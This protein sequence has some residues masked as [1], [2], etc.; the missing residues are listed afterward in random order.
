MSIIE[1]KGLAR[2]FKS[3]KR[4]VNAVRGVDLTVEE[5]EIVG[6]LGPNGAGK[7]TTLRMLTTLL[8]PT[9]GTATVAGQDLLRDP[10]GVRR[11]IGFVPQAIGQTMGG[12]DNQ[13]TVA[14]EILDQAALYR[15]G[16]TE[17]R[18]RAELLTSQ[19]DLTGLD[20][21]L[22]KTLS[23]G[24][25]RRLEIALG[26][27]HE[28][29]LVFLD[30]PTTGLDPQ[31]RSNMWDHIRGVRADLGTTVFLTTHYLDEADALCDRVFI[32]DNGEIVAEGTPDELKRRV[33]GDIV[34]LAVSGS[35][36]EARE[37]LK[38][39][40]IVEDVTVADDG[41]LRL[42]VSHGAEALPSLLR[43]L[44]DAGITMTSINLSRPTLDDVFLTTTGRS[45]R[46]DSPSAAAG[47]S[48]AAGTDAVG[49]GATEPGQP[50]PAGKE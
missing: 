27:V 21:R 17:A 35:G 19:L 46:D 31:S 44:D 38:R 5:G 2:T 11:R 39:Q 22:V 16:K 40:P 42:S 7:T 24:Q 32:I 18:R 28:P 10:L 48:S 12:T 23:G 3:R 13:S 15:I 6:F 25:R 47:T 49:P 1:A 36:D 8:T 37:L 9:A 20:Q 34:T 50:E 30:E 26:L 29:P 45:L 33:S 43:V 41:A 4:T 14:E